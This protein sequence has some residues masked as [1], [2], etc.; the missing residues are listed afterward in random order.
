MAD[1]DEKEKA[2]VDCLKAIDPKLKGDYS[3]SNWTEQIKIEIG[4]LGR[5]LGF[6]VSTHGSHEEH[7]FERGWLYDMIWYK[8]N[9]QQR[10]DQ[11]A[12]VMESEWKNNINDIIYDFEKLMVARAEHRVMIFN[13]TDAKINNYFNEL[14]KI[15]DSSKLS[16]QDD[17]YLL[18]AISINDRSVDSRCHVFEKPVLAEA[19]ATI[20]A[21]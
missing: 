10:L 3:N 18:L 13:T 19:V 17:R 1:I 8:T 20:S 5:N 4:T 7:G 2:I 9:E 16:Q 14:I 21:E 12:L 6:E 11:I 15:I